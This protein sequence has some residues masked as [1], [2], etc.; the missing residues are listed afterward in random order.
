ME[1]MNFPKVEFLLGSI[2]DGWQ[3]INF[4]D[5]DS[6]ED[7]NNLVLGGTQMTARLHRLDEGEKFRKYKAGSLLGPNPPLFDP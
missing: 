5:Q 3:S 6:N 4:D 2:D 1:R 7:A